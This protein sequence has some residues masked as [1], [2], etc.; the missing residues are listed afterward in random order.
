MRDPDKLGAFIKRALYLFDKYFQG[1][2]IDG[3]P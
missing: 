3:K 1:E 2:G